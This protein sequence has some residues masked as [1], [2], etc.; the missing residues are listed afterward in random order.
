MYKITKSKK[1]LVIFTVFKSFLWQQIINNI[2]R[3]TRF[4]KERKYKS[5]RIYYVQF[6]K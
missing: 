1:K 3:K 4:L 5:I 2:Q 6:F